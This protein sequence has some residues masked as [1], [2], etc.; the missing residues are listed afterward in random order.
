MESTACR[1]RKYMNG[2]SDSGIVEPTS[3]DE[4]P[5]RL[6]STSDDETVAP[7]ELM[8]LKID[9][10]RLRTSRPLLASALKKLKMKKFCVHWV[11]K[12]LQ[13]DQKNRQF[14][15]CQELQLCLKSTHLIHFI[16]SL[17]YS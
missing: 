1:N 3:D 6:V 11:P 4:Y 7:V 17:I 9:V 12:H 5:G 14:E 13:P 16:Y 8:V 10:L 2:I 15:V